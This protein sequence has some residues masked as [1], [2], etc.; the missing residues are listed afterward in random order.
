VWSG[1]RKTPESSKNDE[2]AVKV[3]LYII[4]SDRYFHYYQAGLPQE[5]CVTVASEMFKLGFNLG[6]KPRDKISNKMTT[7]KD[8]Y[9]SYKKQL[10][11]LEAAL[12]LNHHS[13]TSLMIL[14]G[15]H[16]PPPPPRANWHLWH[17]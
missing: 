2:I 10:H 17:Y 16:M 14:R 9:R 11:E 1:K 6:D 4:W 13:M 15:L 5:F 12:L 8:A 7:L 3:H